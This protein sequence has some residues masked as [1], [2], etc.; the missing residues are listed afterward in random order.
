MKFTEGAFRDWGYELAK[1]EFGAVEFDGGPWCKLPNGLVVNGTSGDDSLAGGTGND[2]LIGGKGNDTYVVNATGDRPV[3]EGAEGVDLVK[4]TLASYT[5]TDHLDN[6]SYAGTANFGGTGNSLGNKITGGAG[7]DWLHGGA[8]NDTL[9]GGQGADTYWFGRGGGNDTLYNGDSGTSP[10][11]LRFGSGIAEDQLWF[12][13][14]GNDLVVTLRGTGNSDSVR[15][16]GW[17]SASSNQL[18]KFQLSDGTVLAASRVN[19]LVQAMAAFTT[20]SGTP[21]NLTNAQEQSVETVI[22]ANWQNQT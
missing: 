13:K 5:L 15:V 4:T 8:G 21:T 17:Y 16:K 2:M 6:L 18:S 22:A 10:D 14:S 19:Q 3:E 12:G 1:R 9:I 20:S 7:N 11:A